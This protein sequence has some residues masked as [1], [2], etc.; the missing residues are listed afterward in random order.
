[1]K[2][3]IKKNLE[4][5]LSLILIIIL[6]I[7]IA[8]VYRIDFLNALNY[9][10]DSDE[11]IVG[12]MAKHI[13][14]GKT[15]PVFYYG[16]HYMGSFEAMAVSLFFKL[17]GMS[18][19]VLK[20]VPMFFSLLL[21]PCVYFLGKEVSGRKCGLISACYISI[22]P[23]TLVIWS[24]MARGGFI[25]TLVLSTLALII[26]I[27]WLKEENLSLFRIFLVGLILG[28]GWWTNNQIIYV[29]GAIGWF[30]L[31]RVL[32]TKNK[33]YNLYTNFICGTLGFIIGGTPFWIYNL[34][35][36][37]A[38]FGLFHFT[39]NFLT[40]LYLALTVALPILLGGKRFWETDDLFFGSTVFIFLVFGIILL[41]FLLN[42]KSNIF[43]A[44]RFKVTKESAPEVILFMLF[45][46]IL[47]FTAS[48][49]GYLV[50]APR[51][52]LPLYIPISIILGYV[53]AR[54][55]KF[56]LLAKIFFLTVISL[57]LSFSYIKGRLL[58]GA[59]FVFANQRVEHDHSK[60]I[61]VL[62]NKN[63]NW[64]RT[65]YWIGYRLAFETDE[66]VKFLVLGNPHKTRIKEYEAEF[67]KS[68]L[69][70]DKIAILT[71]AKES[72]LLSKALVR[73]GYRFNRE[74]YGN[75]ILIH[76]IYRNFKYP[77]YYDYKVLNAA[78]SHNQ[79]SLNFMFDEDLNTRWGS[80]KAQDPTM[81]VTIEFEESKTTSG[82]EYDLGEFPHDYPRGFEV[83]LV[84]ADGKIIEVLK[85]KGYKA[86]R[87]Y[88]ADTG[89]FSTRWKPVKTKKIILKQTKT[90][91]V[92]DWSIAELRVVK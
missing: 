34:E 92:F 50:Q 38:S 75:Y 52:L 56:N 88:I 36:D 14:E 4:N 57:N 25:E 41:L 76:S 64:I 72:E 21:I 62:K 85:S 55:L 26:F 12:L 7:L 58:P 5:K 42:R 37:F 39:K 65:N 46:C 44:I 47:I 61:K 73:L 48:S 63:I 6:F 3:V 22:A 82:I 10:I 35:N 1:M 51:Y 67:K 33:F 2:S 31:G 74:K 60:I 68:G 24:S 11:A 59:P 16:Q 77:N 45:F 54:V 23:P 71:V 8:A 78:A 84:N 18:S 80:G 17:F 86:L 70:K 20:L 19:K 43:N 89:F 27:R 83:E 91:N 30:A 53:L 9:R 81:H 49:F 40:Q 13:N 66:S 79:E 15:F 28:F 90:D 32:N 29:M 69:E 87:Y